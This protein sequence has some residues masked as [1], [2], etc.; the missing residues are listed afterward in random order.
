LSASID[1]YLIVWDTATNS[2]KQQF[3]SHQGPVLDASWRNESQFASCSTDRSIFVWTVGQQA[4]IRHYSGHRGEVNCVRW[5]GTGNLLA[6]CSDD[7]TVKIWSLNE[8][9]NNSVQD[10]CQHEGVVCALAW[11]NVAS[12]FPPLSS[13]PS[14]SSSSSV[15]TNTRPLLLA[16]GSFDSTVRVW[17]VEDGKCRFSLS[18][19]SHPVT[20]V[21]FC[22]TA[23]LLASASH[24]RLHIWSIKDGSLVR[25]FQSEGG[26]NDI[27]WDSTGHNIA[28]VYSDHSAVVIHLR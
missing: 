27:C 8:D 20:A 9:S 7:C 12:S 13:S 15:D 22:P 6:S 23:P 19:H 3:T 28:A 4:P 18:R 1:R 16:S 25:S 21:A 2:M 24:D 5:D 10:L 17:N 14:S 11:S 26:I